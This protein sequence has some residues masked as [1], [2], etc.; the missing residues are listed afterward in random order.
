M[1]DEQ[2]ISDFDTEITTVVEKLIR[3]YGA[4]QFIRSLI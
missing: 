4:T 2:F 3:I 1:Y